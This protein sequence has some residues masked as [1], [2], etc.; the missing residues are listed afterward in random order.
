MKCPK[1]NAVNEDG[2]KFCSVCGNDLSQVANQ[3]T[4]K[5]ISD[6]QNS[7]GK[8]KV[9]KIIIALVALVVLS[10]GGFLMVQKI[11]HDT[12]MEAY[13]N[14]R[15]EAKNLVEIKNAKIVKENTNNAIFEKNR[16]YNYYFVCDAV[17]P[18]GKVHAD[19]F[20]LTISVKTSSGTSFT[21]KE[22]I[23]E[24]QEHIVY[25]LDNISSDPG[26]IVD[27]QLNVD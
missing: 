9:K 15:N 2:A 13:E 27:I 18:A 14:R 10:V 23:I 20:A 16:T 26:S 22:N 3:N 19:L 25:K 12:H 24:A 8:S 11:Q 4:Q 1:C 6:T 17:N 5:E 7:K 21:I